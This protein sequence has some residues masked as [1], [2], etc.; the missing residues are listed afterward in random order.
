M[1]LKAIF[2]NVD[3]TQVDKLIPTKS[4]DLSDLKIYRRS[5]G[6]YYSAACITFLKIK[7][8]ISSL[9]L[10]PENQTV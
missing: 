2:L 10:L 6:L 5:L 3:L 7:I 1:N 8:R 4:L 9:S